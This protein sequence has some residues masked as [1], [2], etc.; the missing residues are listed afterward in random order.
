MTL[1]RVLRERDAVRDRPDGTVA[2]GPAA[3]AELGRLGVDA[4]ALG[5]ERRRLAFEC[6]DTTERAPTSPANSAAR[7]PRR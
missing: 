2:L 6:L 1:Y 4:A 3:T 7:W 5:H